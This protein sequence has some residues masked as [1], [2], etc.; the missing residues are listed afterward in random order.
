MGNRLFLVHLYLTM[1]NIACYDINCSK[2]DHNKLKPEDKSISKITKKIKSHFLKNLK[3]SERLYH[4]YQNSGKSKCCEKIYLYYWTTCETN[5]YGHRIYKK[6]WIPKS[7]QIL[8]EKYHPRRQAVECDENAIGI[9]DNYEILVNHA[10]IELSLLLRYFLQ[11]DEQ[12]FLTVEVL[13]K[14]KHEVGLVKPTKFIA[15]TKKKKNVFTLEKELKNRQEKL[16]YFDLSF[17]PSDTLT[18]VSFFE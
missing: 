5:I 3:K 6:I 13:E 14:C 8:T 17:T 7:N 1:L 10:L 2:F 9:Y 15:F 16:K 11:V 12:N 18:T 4:L